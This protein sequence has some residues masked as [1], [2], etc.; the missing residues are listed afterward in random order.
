MM[1]TSLREKKMGYDVH[2]P[3][4]KKIGSL[5]F[6]GSRGLSVCDWRTKR[7]SSYNGVWRGWVFLRKKMRENFED[8]ERE[9]E[10]VEQMR[11][12]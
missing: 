11:G 9:R 12:G 10:R 7:C 5:C 2:D 3:R 8:K 1:S 6:L 4:E